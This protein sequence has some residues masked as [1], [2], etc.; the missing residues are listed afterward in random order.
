MNSLGN[1]GLPVQ[2]HTSCVNYTFVCLNLV[3]FHEGKLAKS[4]KFD[5]STIIIR[6]LVSSDQTCHS[7]LR[8][9]SVVVAVKGSKLTEAEE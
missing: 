9:C 8:H 5:S 3:G 4:L 1:N 7:V 6:V 2:A